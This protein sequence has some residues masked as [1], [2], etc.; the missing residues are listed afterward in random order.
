M[1]A[2]QEKRTALTCRTSQASHVSESDARDILGEVKSLVPGILDVLNKIDEK[3][4]AFFS[5]PIPG[6]TGFIRQA[7]EA[8]HEHSTTLSEALV[9]AAPVS[10]SFTHRGLIDHGDLFRRISRARLSS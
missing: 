5:L 8:M 10:N 1:Y 3:K 4:H 9:N 2:C 6:A 7:L